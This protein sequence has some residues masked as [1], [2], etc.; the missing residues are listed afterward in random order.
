MLYTPTPELDYSLFSLD[1]K[2]REGVRWGWLTIKISFDH[3]SSAVLLP[4]ARLHSTEFQRKITKFYP[5]L[6]IWMRAIASFIG[7]K[8]VLV[9][10]DLKIHST[11]FLG[12]N[13]LG[14]R[15]RFVLFVQFCK[16]K[17]ANL[18]IDLFIFIDFIAK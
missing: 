12:T 2:L 15:K 9:T 11:L 1:L 13:N 4:P 16:I 18:Y 17:R 14:H 6:I 3:S 8:N 7:F 10:L 5:H